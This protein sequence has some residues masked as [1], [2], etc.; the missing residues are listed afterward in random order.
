M[1]IHA[2]IFDFDGTILDTESQ[3]FIVVSEMWQAHGA[4]LDL[5]EWRKGLGTVGGF[6]GYDAL[7]IATGRAVDRAHWKALNHERYMEHCM[8]QT[9]RPGVVELLDYADAHNITLAVGSSG[10]RAWVTKWLTHHNLIQRFA[11]VVTRDDVSQVKPSPEIF[12][13]A[14]QNIAINPAQCLVFEDSAHG[15]TAAAR[16]GMRCVAVPIPALID[17]WM[18][19]VTI[20]L[21]SLADL[22]PAQLL[23]EVQGLAPSTPH[24]M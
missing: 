16:A 24:A 5:A 12:L 21:Q 9:L 8:A 6:D 11:T 4:T 1:P 3:D 20:R 14:A 22:T 23:T 2:F 19:A 15:A 7:E 13:L 10:D 17:A 18:P